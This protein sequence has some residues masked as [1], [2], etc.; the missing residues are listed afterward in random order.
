MVRMITLTPPVAG[1]LSLPRPFWML[2]LGVLVNRAGAMVQPFLS[3]YLTRV[4]GFGI[5]ETGAVMAV[6]GVG[7]V[8]SHL[9]AGRLADRFGRRVT[10]TGG[11]LATSASMVLMGAATGFPLVA[12]A[13]FLLGL[14][15]E[16]YR[17]ASQAM[18][19]RKSVV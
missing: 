7:S 19:D 10:L 14:T 12:L 5:G 9:L 16:S 6:F 11:M 1:P 13:A 3:V 15:I 8:L 4:Q 2:W 17:P 18:V